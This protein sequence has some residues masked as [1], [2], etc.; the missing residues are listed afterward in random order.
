GA[1]RKPRTRESISER[2]AKLLS[3]EP[4]PEAPHRDLSDEQLRLYTG[5]GIAAPDERED[6]Y[7]FIAEHPKEGWDE[8]ALRKLEGLKLFAKD[9][10]DVALLPWQEACI[11][12]MLSHP[13]TCTVAGR[14]SGKDFVLAAFV[15]WES[16]TRPN[17]RTVLVSPAQRQ[18]DE[19]M[20]RMLGFAARSD[21]TYY[22]VMPGSREKVTFRKNG[23]AVYA[24][25]A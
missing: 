7:A 18:S 24:L 4:R 21:E 16:I 20:E 15:L 3:Q 25:P 1:T 17:S 2:I 10:L 13:L 19:L 9:L 6:L 14:Q 11:Y 5:V 22:S 8:D 12:L 23:S